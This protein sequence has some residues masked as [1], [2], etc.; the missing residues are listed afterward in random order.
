M[1]T[2]ITFVFQ[3]HPNLVED[4]KIVVLLAREEE[5]TAYLVKTGTGSNEMTKNLVSHSKVIKFLKNTLIKIKLSA[6]L[7]KKYLELKKRIKNY[8]YM[9]F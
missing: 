9:I 8:F 2:K 6:Q 4:V 1:F 7:L 5:T 3:L